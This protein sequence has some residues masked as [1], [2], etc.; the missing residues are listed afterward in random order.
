MHAMLYRAARDHLQQADAI[1]S[2][3]DGDALAV[4]TVIRHVV[5]ILNEKSGTG[6]AAD[7][8]VPLIRRDRRDE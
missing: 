7:N 1:L 4:R 6:P 8:V 5:T 2:R 3:T